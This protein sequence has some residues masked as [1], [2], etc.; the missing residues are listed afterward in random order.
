MIKTGK[1]TAAQRL[2]RAARLRSHMLV[3]REFARMFGDYGP[4]PF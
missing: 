2:Q 3:L 4:A 1:T